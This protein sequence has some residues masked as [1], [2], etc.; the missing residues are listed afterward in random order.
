MQ[1]KHTKWATLR[2]LTV[3]SLGVAALVATQVVSADVYT[4]PVGFVTMTALGTG[5]SPFNNPY[6]SLVGL[7]MTQL[8]VSRG[9][10]TAGVANQ[11]GVNATLTPGQF[12]KTSDGYPAYWI[13]ITSGAWVGYQTDIVSNDAANVYTVV[14]LS[15]GLPAT[16]KI[17]PHWTIG[18]L[19]GPQNQAGL[20]GGSLTTADQ[21]QVWSVGSQAYTSIYYYKTTGAIGGTG[22][23]SALSTS[24]N[25]TNVPVYIDQSLYI[26]RKVSTNL[27]IKVVGGVKLTNTVS[28]IWSNG[29]GAAGSTVT[30]LGNAYPAGQPLGA[31][32]LYTGNPSTGL[33]GGSLTTADQLQ[34][35]APGSQAY[36]T[37]YYYKTTGAIGGTGWR[38]ATSTS[39]DVS[40][41]TIPL[42]G[43]VY[44]LRRAGNPTFNWSAPQPFVQ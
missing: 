29:L 17:Y 20:L 26:A 21:I 33:L 7:G 5:N 37:I 40:T 4:D 11:V 12:N 30:I 1:K 27:D 42:G 18:T 9:N 44:V 16:Y 32:G 28:T 13:E 31:S 36:T 3:I 38:S 10:A 15:G 25:V 14:D 35:W 23:R 8:P 19:F 22:W 41:N 43:S 2:K 6:V 34:I 39:I 24:I